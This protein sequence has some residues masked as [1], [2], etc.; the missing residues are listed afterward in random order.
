VAIEMAFSVAPVA[1]R[2]KHGD[3]K[4][5]IMFTCTEN[6][7][8]VPDCTPFR[9]LRLRLICHK[10]YTRQNCNCNYSSLATSHVTP[11]FPSGNIKQYAPLH[12]LLRSYTPTVHSDPESIA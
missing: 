12:F 6:R 11:P 9:P 10:A 7:R 5:Q 3:I 1:P 4:R 8:T 2:T